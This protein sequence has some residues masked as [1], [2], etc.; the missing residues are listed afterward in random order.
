MS[1]NYNCV[2]FICSFFYW[3]LGLPLKNKNWYGQ[4]FKL[5]V[6]VSTKKFR[7]YFKYLPVTF[8]LLV[9]IAVSRP[10]LHAQTLPGGFSSS[11]VSGQWDQAVG[12]TFSKD[13]NQM[14]VW[15]KVG[16]VWV[17]KNNQK[18]LLIDISEEVGDW[19]DFG[20]LGF[21]LDPQFETNGFFYLLYTVG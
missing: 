7:P 12:L 2:R 17:V 8:T 14:F 4:K 18:K 15:E 20:L 16:K 5:L 11:L 9:L 6:Y 1:N 10:Q 21:A 19:R 13:G 3:F